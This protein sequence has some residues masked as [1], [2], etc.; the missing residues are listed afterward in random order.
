MAPIRC[1]LFRGLGAFVHRGHRGVGLRARCV[2]SFGSAHSWAYH[3]NGRD[4][5]L[6][7]S[8]LQ[9]RALVW[10]RL[11]GWVGGGVGRSLVYVSYGSGRRVSETSSLTKQKGCPRMANSTFDLKDVVTFSIASIGAVLGIINTWRAVDRDRPKLRVIPAHAIPVGGAD[12]RLTFCIGVVN[13]SVVPLT[14]R[15][16]GVFYRGTN[17]RGTIL[18][19][20][21]ADG[22]TLPRRL[23]PRTSISIYAEAK[24]IGLA[25]HRIRSAYAM[26]ACD[27]TFEGTSPALAQIAREN[28]HR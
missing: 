9:G 13:L 4:H 16:V 20:V 5:G 1:P 6:G 18:L 11:Q 19:P 28:D 10:W 24:S 22:G 15:E 27:L 23:E 8:D 26:T 7:L 2:A 25:G 3:P 21:M 14:V 17:K 12:P